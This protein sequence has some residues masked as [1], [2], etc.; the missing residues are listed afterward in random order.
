M[1]NQM[2]ALV[3][4]KPEEGLWMET[5]P[6]PEIGRREVLIKVQKSAICGTDVH[7]W[8]WDEWSQKAVPV[9]L[10]EEHGFRMQPDD[11]EAAIAAM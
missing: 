11:L 10:R 7:I 1:S 9:P 8:N 3:K 2:R 4:A 6:V 5:V